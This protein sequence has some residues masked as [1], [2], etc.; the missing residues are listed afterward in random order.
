MKTASNPQVIDFFQRL[1]SEPDFRERFAEETDPTTTLARLRE[2][3]YDFSYQEFRETVEHLASASTKSL[4]DS[5]LEGVAGG[6][7]VNEWYKAMGEVL[8]SIGDQ[9]LA[10]VF[11]EEGVVGSASDWLG[12]QLGGGIK[13]A[14]SFLANNPIL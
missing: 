9:P 3:G 2:A 4:P 5:A 13:K 14:A 6:G 10:G 12:K 8:T 7:F 1:A 11:G